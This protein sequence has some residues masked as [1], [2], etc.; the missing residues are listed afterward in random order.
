MPGVT[1]QELEAVTAIRRVREENG[2]VF[3]D[4]GSAAVLTDLVKDG[5]LDWTAPAEGDWLLFFFWIHGTGQTAEPSVSTS[6]TINYFDRAGI[7]AFTEYWDDVVLTPQLR[8]DLYRNLRGMMYMDSLELGTF[9]RGGQLW[10]RHF[11]EEFER[12][13]RK[14]VV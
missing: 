8:E 7:R 5:A 1:K 12:V 14:S 9:G 10:S 3:L 6:Y 11:R 2:V 13:D 4:R